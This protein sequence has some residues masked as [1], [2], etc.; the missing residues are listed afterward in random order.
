MTD[1]PIKIVVTRE[2]FDEIV[3]IDDSMHFLE[4][5]NLEA[6]GYMCNF[7]MNGNDTYLSVEEARKKFKKIPRKELR[8]YISMFV[9]AVGD[10]FVNPP[11]GA[12]L[13]EQ[14]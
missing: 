3:S 8:T 4:I 2:R 7:V 1:E 14:S 5:T 11:N 12:D 9:K 13:E 6:Y 10:A